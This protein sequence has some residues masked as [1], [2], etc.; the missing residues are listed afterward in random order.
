MSSKQKRRNSQ[1]KK[2]AKV[3]APGHS[4]RQSVEAPAAVLI[5]SCYGVD[6]E[7]HRS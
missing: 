5:E 3:I 6:L 4:N 1:K 7:L 2:E